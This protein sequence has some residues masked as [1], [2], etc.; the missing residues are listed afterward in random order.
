MRYRHLTAG[1][2]RIQIGLQR[3]YV[4]GV[5]LKQFEFVLFAQQMVGNQ[6]RTGV[7]EQAALWVEMV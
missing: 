3:A 4:C 7:I 5:H 2:E 1:F 6:G